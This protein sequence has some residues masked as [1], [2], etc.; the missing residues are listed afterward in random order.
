[1]R[2]LLRGSPT[3]NPIMTNGLVRLLTAIVQRVDDP[4]SAPSLLSRLEEI[5][6]KRAA[7]LD[8]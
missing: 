2:C 3:S 1:M 4:A 8:E 6:K 7:V 5:Y